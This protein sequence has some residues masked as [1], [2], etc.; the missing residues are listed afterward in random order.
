MSYK[1]G[2]GDGT[3][4]WHKDKHIESEM[5]NARGWESLY[6]RRPGVTNAGRTAQTFTIEPAAATDPALSA[7]T[8]AM[9]QFPAMAQSSNLVKWHDQNAGSRTTIK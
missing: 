4:T 7:T 9:S 3:K 2:S 5:Q 6:K 8:R 1:A